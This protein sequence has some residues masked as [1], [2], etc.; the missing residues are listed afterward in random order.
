MDRPGEFSSR[1]P[2][3]G[4][5]PNEHERFPVVDK[6]DKILR[7][8]SRSEVMRITLRHRAVHMLISTQE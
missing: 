8:A 6:N 3:P 1:R 2:V 7:D 4:Y 5:A